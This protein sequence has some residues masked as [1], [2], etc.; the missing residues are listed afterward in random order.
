MSQH[1]NSIQCD[2]Q[3]YLKHADQILNLA[4]RQMQA[5]LGMV[6][7]TTNPRKRPQ[8]GAVPS[9]A[10]PAEESTTSAKDTDTVSVSSTDD[11]PKAKKSKVSIYLQLL[12]AGYNS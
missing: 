2:K 8:K 3:D 12:G 7:T 6:D 4:F 9:A 11:Q 5:G 10:P 1:H